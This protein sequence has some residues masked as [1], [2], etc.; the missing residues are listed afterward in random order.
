M[1]LVKSGL[2]TLAA[3][4]LFGLVSVAGCSADGSSDDVG[5]S[6]ETEP[7]EGTAQLPPSS[8]GSS[9][10]G[11]ESTDAGKT[12]GGKK[13]AGADAGP[14]PPTPGTPC[15]KVDEIKKKKCGAC[16]EQSTICVGSPDGG[17]PAWSE[18]SPCAGE[19]AG[20]CIPGTQENEACGN[21]GTRVRTCSQYCSWSTGTCTG[22]PA[23]ACTPGGVDL[24]N[25]GCGA[26]QYRQRTCSAACAY[27][28]FSACMSAP[29]TIEVP[30]TASGV[31]YTFATLSASQT[32]GRIGGTCPN[33]T[34][35]TT[36]TSPYLHLTVHN[37]NA[38][39][40]VVTIFSS[41]APNGSV[42]KTVLAAYATT[43]ANDA[44]RKACVKGTNS[45]G[46]T[47]LTGSSD[48]AS[49]HGS[50]AVTVP[51]GG[52]VVVHLAGEL[53]TSVGTVKVSVRTDKLL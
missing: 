30:P 8:G 45:F 23:N 17:P 51:A 16:G 44:Q 26:D 38:K 40:A 4:G 3:V 19:I 20:G 24:S 34:I 12:D 33:A 18:Y 36:V 29:T 28:N 2:V 27:D 7:T 35:S 14:P 50:N 25:A 31:N 46:D 9:S 22:Q 11:G 47:T 5:G 52:S 10:S 37:G 41:Q 1:G 32:A 49:L 48:F 13:D 42:V 6:T 43:P 39:D 53:A 21:C 15:T